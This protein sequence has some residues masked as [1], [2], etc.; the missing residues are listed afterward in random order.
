MKPSACRV[1]NGE[2]DGAH[3][4]A[5]KVLRESASAA[6]RL[7]TG[8]MSLRVEKRL[9]FIKESQ[10]KLDLLVGCAS[11]TKVEDYQRQRQLFERSVTRA[12][13]NFV[14]QNKWAVAGSWGRRR[15]MNLRRRR[16]AQSVRAERELR[17]MEERRIKEWWK[18][19]ERMRMTRATKEYCQARDMV[20]AQIWQEKIWHKSMYHIK[21]WLA[22][23]SL[24]NH[25]KC[26]KADAVKGKLYRRQAK[27]AK[28]SAVLGFF[29]RMTMIKLRRHA[30]VTIL[31]N[32]LSCLADGNPLRVFA[33]KIRWA[34]VKLQQMWRSRRACSHA[35]LEALCLQFETYAIRRGTM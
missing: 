22:A 27:I 2:E 13:V 8:N 20:V 33:K 9:E 4:T 24:A 14:E 30:A 6:D 31:V 23:V 29:A 5:A 26:W 35:H 12:G 17:A 3:L 16:M 15:E 21:G 25:I 18:S 34:V 28:A 11:S 7:K 10:T 32:W 1:T 19:S